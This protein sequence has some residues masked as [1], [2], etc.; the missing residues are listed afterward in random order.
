M[1]DISKVKLPNNVVYNLKDSRVDNIGSSYDGP[2]ETLTFIFPDY[3][4][5]TPTVTQ[6]SNGILSIS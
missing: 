2:N 1:A 5:P 4:I 6:D 3:D